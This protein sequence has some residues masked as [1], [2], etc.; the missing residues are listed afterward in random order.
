LLD[1]LI[2]LTEEEQLAFVE[3]FAGAASRAGISAEQ[4]AAT[5]RELGRMVANRPS[6]RHFGSAS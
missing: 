6:A 1:Q 2:Q 3:Q 5:L 4:A